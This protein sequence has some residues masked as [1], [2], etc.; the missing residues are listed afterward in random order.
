MLPSDS[1]GTAKADTAA[2]AARK[3]YWSIS[4]RRGSRVRLHCRPR[5]RVRRKV[6]MTSQS[7]QHPPL[8]SIGPSSSTSEANRRGQIRDTAWKCGTRVADYSAKWA[9]AIARIFATQSKPPAKQWAGQELLHIIVHRFFTTWPKTCP[10]VARR[11]PIDS[12]RLWE[13]RRP[14]LK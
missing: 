9:W 7:A 1:E 13:N 5:N 3:D 11:L 12:R 4:N 14:R 8:T 2:R 6:W 10:N